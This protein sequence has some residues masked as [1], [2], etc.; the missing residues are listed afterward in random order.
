MQQ[1]WKDLFSQ[2]FKIG[3]SGDERDS[4]IVTPDDILEP[5]HL[6]I[7]ANEHWQTIE[8]PFDADDWIFLPYQTINLSILGLK[9]T[10]TWS[11]EDTNLPKFQDDKETV[12]GWQAC[13]H[14]SLTCWHGKSINDRECMVAHVSASQ[15]AARG[16]SLQALLQT[17]QVFVTSME[18]SSPWEWDIDSMKKIGNV[19]VPWEVQGGYAEPLVECLSDILFKTILPGARKTWSFTSNGDRE[20]KGLVL[21]AL[22]LPRAERLLVETPHAEPVMSQSIAF[23]QTREVPTDIFN[24][25]YPKDATCFALASTMATFSYIHHDGMSVRTVIQVLT[26]KK[27]WFFFCRVACCIQDTHVDEFMND[28]VPGF[29]PDPTEWE[30]EVV[31]LEPGTVLFMCPNTHHA[32]ITLK[33]CIVLGQHFYMMSCIQDTVAGQVICGPTGWQGSDVHVPD[34]STQLGLLDVIALGNFCIFALAL[35]GEC[36][37]PTKDGVHL[38]ITSY[39][40]IIRFAT[41][42]FIL[43]G[44]NGIPKTP[45]GLNDDMDDPVDNTTLCSIVQGVLWELFG[46]SYTGEDLLT[47]SKMD[48]CFD[49]QKWDTEWPAMAQEVDA[50][51]ATSI[52][53]HHRDCNAPINGEKYIQ[54]ARSKDQGQGWEVDA[55]TL[56]RSDFEALSEGGSVP[57]TV[58]QCL[59][60]S[61]I[62][63]HNASHQEGWFMWPGMDYHW[64]QSYAEEVEKNMARPGYCCSWMLWEHKSG[65]WILIQIDLNVKCFTVWDSRQALDASQSQ[66]NDWVLKTLF[67]IFDNVA[68]QDVNHW[69][70]TL[71]KTAGV[72]FPYSGLYTCMY[73]WVIMHNGGFKDLDTSIWRFESIRAVLRAEFLDYLVHWYIENLVVIKFKNHVIKCFTMENVDLR[74]LKDT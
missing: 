71:D 51:V 14:D 48:L 28:W 66:A 34:I 8:E 26:G 56:A 40:D 30:A 18:E 72:K 2:S 41:C 11:F 15:L 5:S 73:A 62:L 32:V 12:L 23:D 10:M 1:T 9:S 39:K 49:H 58:L 27:I 69:T 50:V 60:K 6:D 44:P 4:L 64:G 74:R 3:G 47:A 33:N 17:K 7:C 22:Y 19:D 42:H 61:I 52:K 53:E 70:M 59:L 68:N 38:A 54:L 29:I 31:V 67:G 24:N 16:V 63:E 46:T 43:Y 57:S 55:Y 35:N 36:K 45:Y 65:H 25:H 21:N 37:E 20:S 13:A